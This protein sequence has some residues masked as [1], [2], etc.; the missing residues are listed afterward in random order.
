MPTIAQQLTTKDVAVAVRQ[1]GQRREINDPGLS[2]ALRRSY[3]LWRRLKAIEAELSEGK[4]LIAK[5]AEEFSGGGST[6]SFDAGDVTCTVTFRHEAV[7]PEDNVAELKKLLGRRFKDLV[8]T[9]VRRLAT[10]RLVGEADGDTLSLIRL[11]RLSP[12]LKWGTKGA[13]NPSA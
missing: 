4:G 8:R 1:G 6:V 12:Q 13:S 9:K 11:R 3:A 10:S 2:D 5:R 7:I